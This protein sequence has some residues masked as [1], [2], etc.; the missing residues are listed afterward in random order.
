[1]RR[2]YDRYFSTGL[3]SSR[4]PRPNGHLL[5]LILREA[6]RTGARI[7]DF[8]CGTGRYALALAR[9]R[10]IE[11]LA[12]DISSAAIEDLSRRADEMKA[13]GALAGKI[14]TLCGSF[15]DLERRLEGDSGFDLVALLFGVLGHIPKRAQRVAVL[16]SLRLKL[17]PGGRLIVT[18]PNRARRFAEE[19]RACEELVRSGVLEPGDIQYQRSTGTEEIDLYY[20]LYSPAEFRAELAD[21][22]FAVPHLQAESVFAESSVLTSPVRAWVDAALCRLTPVSL[23]YGMVAVARPVA[24]PAT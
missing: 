13:A 2:S 3:Y 17:R 6:G 7:L 18:V 5:N 20:H 19:Q 11:V 22:G 8:G 23:A 15:D 1:M 24:A 21:A 9:Q 10:H 16:R 14:E 12:Y 4:Y